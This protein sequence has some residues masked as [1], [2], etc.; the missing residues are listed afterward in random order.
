[1]TD[2][3]PLWEAPIYASD[4]QALAWIA[5]LEGI[6]VPELIHR[7]LGAYLAEH[8]RQIAERAYARIP[9]D[10]RALLESSR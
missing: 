3:P 4:N 6:T 1:V 7:A 8:G 5:E 2:D 10:V 9:A